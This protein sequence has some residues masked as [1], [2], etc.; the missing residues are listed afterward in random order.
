MARGGLG[1]DVSLGWL[2]LLACPVCAQTGPSRVAALLP[3]MF[4]VPYLVAAVIA[5]VVRRLE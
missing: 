4:T 1:V 5:R 2:V 3:L